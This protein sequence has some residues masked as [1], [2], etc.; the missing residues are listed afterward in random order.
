[1]IVI[2]LLVDIISCH[3]LGLFG[4]VVQLNSGVHARD[5]LE[6][7]PMLS[8]LRYALHRAGEDHPGVQGRLGCT[9]LVMTPLPLSVKNGT[10]Q[11][12]VDIP[13]ERDRRYGPPP[14]KR[15][16]DD[17]GSGAMVWQ[18]TCSWV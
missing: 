8:V 18:L 13:S 9:G 11:S 1:M 16:D 10:L 4:H 14:P 15:S 5:A 6:C 7:T 3:R 17:G 12:D 2:L